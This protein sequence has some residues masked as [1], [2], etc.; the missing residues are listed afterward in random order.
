MVS[1]ATRNPSL[2]ELAGEGDY[3][4]N[5]MPVPKARELIRRFL[6]PISGTERLPL[7]VAPQR[8]VLF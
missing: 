6:Q 8:P 3:D 2:Q 4:P 1:P 7:R 5:S